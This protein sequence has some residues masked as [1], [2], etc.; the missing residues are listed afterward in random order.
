MKTARLGL[1]AFYFLVAGC[2]KP[3]TDSPKVSA[4]G[5]ERAADATA[6]QQGKEAEIAA[7]LAKLSPEDRKLAEQQ[8]FCAVMNDSR[9]GSM[10]TPVKITV[11]D[12]PVFLCCKGCTK[13]AQNNPDQTVARVKELKAKNAPPP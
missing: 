6:D 1:A 13:K 7:S 3:A 12:Q 10:G 5:Q 2:Q 8:R 11:Q 9:L 4:T